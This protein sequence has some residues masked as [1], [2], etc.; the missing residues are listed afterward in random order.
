[1]ILDRI[2]NTTELARKYY[3]KKHPERKYKRPDQPLRQFK[4]D[5]NIDFELVSNIL[6]KSLEVQKKKLKKA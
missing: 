5:K 3:E 6:E 4:Q 2:F 1:M